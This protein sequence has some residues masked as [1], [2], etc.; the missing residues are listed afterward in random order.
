MQDLIEFK[1]SEFGFAFHCVGSVIHLV[2]ISILI[3]YI[4]YVYINGS[5]ELD[6]DG[7][8]LN[9]N[10]FSIILLTGII[11]PLCYSII[12]CFKVGPVE[13]LSEFGNWFDIFYIIG[14]ILMS[15][16]HLVTSPFFFVSKLVMIFVITQSI[17]RTFKSMRIIALYSPIVTM[18]QT[19]VYDLR[20]FLL[21]YGIL[22]GFFTLTFGVLGNGNPNPDINPVLALAKAEALYYGEG[23][24]GIEYLDIHRLIGSFI[25]VMKVSVGD[26]SII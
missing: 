9:G 22:L 13:Y 18:L 4:N 23:Y 19:V 15:I 2:Q 24:L 3:F 25:D 20:I 16:L 6:T 10:P 12:Q 1:W 11:Y 5:L 14:S 26:F 7:K 8:P 17:F 21:F